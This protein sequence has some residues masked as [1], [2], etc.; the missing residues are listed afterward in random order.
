MSADL[1]HPVLELPRGRRGKLTI[2]RSMYQGK[3]FTKLTLWY[4]NGDA[5]DPE[6]VRGATLTIRDHELP[7][8]IS[9]LISI[10][11][12][13][14]AGKITESS[15]TETTEPTTPARAPTRHRT[16][17]AAEQIAEDKALF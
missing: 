6:L 3:A 10:D 12:K 8:V 13:S 15:F 4:P 9:C 17:T 1:D 11:K 7:S 5:D 2:S 14:R 16:M